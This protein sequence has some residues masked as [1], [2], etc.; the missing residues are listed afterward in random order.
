MSY[1]D[2]QVLGHLGTR[3]FHP[4][5]P[6][7]GM[8][9]SPSSFEVSK[10]SLA[11]ISRC[12]QENSSTPG[13]LS[14][15]SHYLVSCCLCSAHARLAFTMAACNILVQWHGLLPNVSGF[16]PLSIAEFSL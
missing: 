16:V 7:P 15:R 12:V 11:G 10:P 9:H 6:C 5:V 3:E 13:R 1:T 14:L 2:T 4:W 8:L